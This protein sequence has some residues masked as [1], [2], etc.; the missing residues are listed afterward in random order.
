MIRPDLIDFES[1]YENSLYVIFYICQRYRMIP[2]HVEK[3]HL[4]LDLNHMKVSEIPFKKI[5]HI[6]TKIGIV[7][8]EN[9]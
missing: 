1:N 2:Y 3:V 9:S 8:C 5:Y 6:L 4:I 7:Y